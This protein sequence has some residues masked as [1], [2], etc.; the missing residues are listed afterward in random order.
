M[1][2]R[3]WI[4]LASACAC[5]QGAR[6]RDTPFLQQARSGEPSG[7]LPVIE[8][9][10]PT[11]DL[12][13]EFSP[14]GSLTRDLLGYWVV[15][16]VSGNCSE[17][18]DY[19]H[20]LPEGEAQTVRIDNDSCYPEQ[21]GTFVTPTGY[22]L[23][24]RELTLTVAQTADN[25]ESVERFA[26]AAA[27]LQGRQVLYTALYEPVDPLHWRRTY[28]QE[29][30][31]GGELSSRYSAS[32]D[33][34]FDVPV[35]VGEGGGSAEVEYHFEYYFANPCCLEEPTTLYTGH[36]GPLELQF[37]PGPLGQKVELRGIPYENEDL[38]YQFGEMIN[39]AGRLDS[40]LYR[41]ELWLDPEA[42]E[43]LFAPQSSYRVPQESDNR[44]GEPP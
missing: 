31:D 3:T 39:L 10:S 4:V 5:A 42:P 38:P 35:S 17:F 34:R 43:F 22:S 15:H 1:H 12:R 37:G 20:L 2:G 44:L 26:V 25:F 18:M 16:D 8:V 19:L 40:G 24:G 9:T 36:V 7:D 27:T 30:H 21:R 28:V 33:F 32:M 6:E 11:P 13:P 29:T 14:L 41:S 23:D